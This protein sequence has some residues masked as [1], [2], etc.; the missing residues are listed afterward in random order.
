MK[1]FFAEFKKF[2]QRGNVVDLAVG[3]IIGGAF[4]KITSSL[5]NDIIM[6]LITA[7]LSMLGLQGGTQGMCIVLNGVPQYLPD[8]TG[9]LTVA[10]PEAI[11]WNYG[12][13][14]QVILDFLLIAMVL[15]LIIK[16]INFANSEMSTVSNKN[17]VLS[18]EEVR[19][20]RK[21]GKSRKEIAQ[22]REQRIAELA[23]QKR[24]ADEEAKRNA[25]P[26]EQQLLAQILEEL[27]NK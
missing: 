14:I 25:P 12:N 7:V 16:A 22:A 3:V 15:F 11:L 10:N 17:K 4:S 6:P 1:K 8:A 27:K 23:E 24:I 20:L 18:R 13:F 19:A 9:E 5:V 26:T 2:I 21:Q